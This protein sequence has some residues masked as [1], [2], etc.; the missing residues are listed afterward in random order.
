MI[1]Y[2][3]IRISHIE[4]YK[5]DRRNFWIAI[6]TTGKMY[7]NPNEMCVNSSE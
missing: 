4:I 5:Y 1:L 7:D 6:T 2:S 3:P